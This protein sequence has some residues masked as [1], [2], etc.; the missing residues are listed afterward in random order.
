MKLIQ[1]GLKKILDPVLAFL[2]FVIIFPVILIL[3]ALIKMESPGSMFFKQKRVGKSEKIFNIYKFRSM[4]VTEDSTGDVAEGMSAE[5]ARSNYQ[6]TIVNDPRITPVGKF[7]RKYYLDEL[8]QLINVLKGEMSFVGPRPYTPSEIADYK[9]SYWKKRHLVKPGIT[10]L[11]QIFLNGRNG[12][13]Y[14]R[15]CLDVVYVRN[16]SLSLDIY[17]LFHTFLKLIR[18]SS[19]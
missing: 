2:G 9:L 18:G 14:S 8:P 11:S 1:N 3:G 7:I 13:N 6:T 17:I 5:E 10:G 15:I 16:H 19:F 12:K 4:Y